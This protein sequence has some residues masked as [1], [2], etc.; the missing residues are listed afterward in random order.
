MSKSTL[1][2]LSYKIYW[3]GHQQP[4]ERTIEV[5]AESGADWVGIQENVNRE[6]EDQTP[7][8]ARALGFPM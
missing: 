4:L 3:G 8:I 7:E 1:S 5:I 6:Y 2:V